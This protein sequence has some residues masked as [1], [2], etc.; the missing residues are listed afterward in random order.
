[1]TYRM[2]QCT[3]ARLETLNNRRNH[4]V[5]MSLPSFL[6]MYQKFRVVRLKWLISELGSVVLILVQREPCQPLLVYCHALMA[7][8]KRHG[9]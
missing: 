6:L 7:T 8:V 9:I 4:C 2:L 5:S 3:L 1:M